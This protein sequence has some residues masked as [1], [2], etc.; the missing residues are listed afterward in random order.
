[1][2]LFSRKTKKTEETKSVAVVSA[3]STPSM[4]DVRSNIIGPRITE[5]ATMTAEKNVYVFNI[6]KDATKPN[7][8]R[9]IVELYKV[10]PVK[11][12]IA[13]TPKKRTFVRGKAGVKAG[14]RKAYVYLKAGDKIEI[15]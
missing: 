13:H 4:Y 1:M 7:I 8:S 2:A 9:A 10:K 3:S 11:V 5:K 15:A 14:V 6:S 12:A